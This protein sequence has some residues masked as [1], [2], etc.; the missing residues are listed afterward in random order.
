[1]SLWEH[2]QRELVAYISSDLT[3][4]MGSTLCINVSRIYFVGD[5]SKTHCCNFRAVN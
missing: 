5:Q 2:D 4:Y 3:V 1:M